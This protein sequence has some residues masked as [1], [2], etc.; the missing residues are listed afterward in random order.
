MRCPLAL[1]LTAGIAVAQTPNP[2]RVLETDA[3]MFGVSFSTDSG[4]LVGL[5][6]DGKARVWVA[7]SGALLRTIAWEAG[8]LFTAAIAPGADLMAAGGPDKSVKLWNLNTGSTVHRLTWHTQLLDSGPYKFSQDGKLLATS[9]PGQVRLWELPSARLRF[10][11]ADGAGTI[12]GFAFSPDGRTLA[13]ANE[14]T[15]LRV[16]DAHSGKLLRVIDELPLLTTCL[17]FSRD[18]AYLISA[19]V[20]QNVYI[21][22]TKTW[23][24]VRQFEEGQ[25]ESVLSMDLSPD[26]RIL[27][28]G[29]LDPATIDNPAHLIL[30]DLNSGKALK[31]IRLPHAVTGVA[32]SPDA[33]RIAMANLENDVKLWQVSSLLER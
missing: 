29:G 19:G 17:T 14:D 31:T 18:G 15:N 30:W 6:L 4:T 12:V 5:G 22:D 33:R 25:P 3:R 27:A 1:A 13:G 16:W 2:D 20:D 7:S 11:T 21:W 24:R 10:E 23:R 26:G 9:G 8:Y 32:F 28:T